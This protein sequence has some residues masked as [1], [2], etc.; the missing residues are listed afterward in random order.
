MPPSFLTGLPLARMAMLMLVCLPGAFVQAKQPVPGQLEIH[1]IALGQGGGT[2]I[3]GPDGTMILYDFGRV[4]GKKFLVKYLQDKIGLES[5]DHIHYAMI[6]HGDKDHYYGYKDV[7]DYAG[8]GV[9]RAN[10]EPGTTK[11]R[12]STMLSHWFNPAKKT[13]A[14]AFKAIPVGLRIPLGDGAEA[15]VIAANGVVLNDGLPA[16]ISDENDRSIAL[17]IRYGHFSYIL[18]GDLGSGSEACTAHKTSQ[19]NV[20][21][22]VA[23]ALVKNGLM[24]EE[25]GVDVMHIA[26]HGSESSTSAAY[27][28]KMKPKLAL[29][30]VGEDQGTFLHPRRDVVERVLLDIN[31]PSCV[32]APPVLALLQTGKG[33]DLPCSNTGC[34]SFAGAEV[35]DIVVRTDGDKDYTVEVAQA[36]ARVAR[37]YIQLEGPPPWRIPLSKAPKRRER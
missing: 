30:S 9:L 2:L 16:S 17:F 4:P 5:G 32:V 28:N 25:R 13:K 20:Q 21:E 27:F 11:T 34:T 22:R 26:H 10:Y 6:S 29:V 7:V 37:K 14:G 18:D 3:V 36:P 33:A 8:I 1:Y 24:S 12:S 19:R 23:R 15:H 35:G 31:R